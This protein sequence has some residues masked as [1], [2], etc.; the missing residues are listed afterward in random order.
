MP[1]KPSYEELEQ[2]VKELEKEALERKRVKD[3]LLQE[4]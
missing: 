3:A 1:K 2:R 4:K